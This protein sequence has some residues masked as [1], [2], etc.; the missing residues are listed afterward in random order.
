VP[1]RCTSGSI[2]PL[3]GFVTVGLLS[4]SKGAGV[5]A[6]HRVPQAHVV[7]SSLGRGPGPDH[8]CSPL[9]S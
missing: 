1:R 4:R 7:A 3:R 5:D 9:R 6:P 2:R 8:R